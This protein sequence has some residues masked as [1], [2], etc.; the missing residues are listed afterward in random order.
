MISSFQKD[1]QKNCFMCNLLCNVY[2][3]IFIQIRIL[4]LN[5][6]DF[7]K[8]AYTLYTHSLMQY[9]VNKYRIHLIIS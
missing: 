8:P 1:W 2:T 3:Q 4:G 9:E 7:Y 6:M 5:A